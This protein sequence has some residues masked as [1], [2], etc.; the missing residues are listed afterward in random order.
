M[1][2]SSTKRSIKTWIPATVGLVLVLVVICLATATYVVEEGKQA[3]VTQF[4]KPVRYVVDAGLK[5]KV[6]FVQEVHLLEKRLLPWDGAPKSVK[7]RDKK[8]IFI[9]VWGRWKIV[10]PEVFFRAVRTEQRGQ[11]ILD[12]LADSTVLD[13]V[14]RYNL[15]DVVRSSDAELEYE[16]DELA[17]SIRAW[18]DGVTTDEDVIETVVLE[19]DAKPQDVI[20]TA[21]LE[22]GSMGREQI[23]K[24]ILEAVSEMLKDSYGMELSVV[25][26][27]RVNYIKS[28]KEAVYERMRSE[29]LRV[30]SLFKSQAI[31]EENIILGKTRFELDKIEG[32]MELQSATIRGEADAEVIKMT[33]LAY[34]QPP[35]TLEFYTFLRRLE[36]FENSLGENSRVIL[37]TDGEIFRLFEDSGIEQ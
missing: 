30:A 34:G 13:V 26:I 11:K 2:H 1:M 31:E 36:V 9:D 3:V 25:H 21:V 29:R 37:S 15:I 6:P 4:G 18:D 24:D 22:D 19:E 32:E 12:D 10:D 33:A 23:E 17:D 8:T 35:E 28:V 14:A 5:F 27:K 16:S 20:E 7:T